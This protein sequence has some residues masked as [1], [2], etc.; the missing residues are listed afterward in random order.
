MMKSNE[1]KSDR[2]VRV[3]IGV[4]ALVYA[5]VVLDLLSGLT[6]LGVLVTLFGVGMILTGFLGYC[7]GYS[8]IGISTQKKS[9]CGCGTG[10]CQ[11]KD[12]QS[13]DDQASDDQ[14][15]DE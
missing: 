13:S 8:V 1:S 9:C 15:K 14:S 3:V 7:P 12:D 2:A 6:I 10:S 5:V 4:T 11:S